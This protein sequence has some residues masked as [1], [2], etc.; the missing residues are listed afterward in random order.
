MITDYYLQWRHIRI[1]YKMHGER[2]C[3]FWKTGTFSEKTKTLRF[4]VTLKK[5][6]NGLRK[7]FQIYVLMLP[8]PT[9]SRVL[10]L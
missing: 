2:T 9:P 1:V 5:G 7:I 10:Y 6:Q 8:L 4:F 3:K